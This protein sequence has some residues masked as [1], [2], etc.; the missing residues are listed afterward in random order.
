M[1]RK[2]KILGTVGV[3]ALTAGLTLTATGTASAAPNC[4]Y[5][6]DLGVC[7]TYD[8]RGYNA[9]VQI[10]PDPN[11]AGGDWMDFNL[12]CGSQRFG[13]NGAFRAYPGHTYTY[14]FAVGS[15]GSCVV[16][17]YDRSTGAAWASPAMSR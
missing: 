9:S 8:P 11:L 13:D 7:N 4:N 15:Q 3:V 5:N 2:S 10:G 17:L 6:N 16:W 1:N 12:V 14:T